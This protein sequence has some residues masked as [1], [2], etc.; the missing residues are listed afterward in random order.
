MHTQW[1]RVQAIL[2]HVVAPVL[3]GGTIYVLWRSPRLLVFS[4]LRS[5]GLDPLIEACRHATAP[6]LAFLHAWSLNSMPDGLW[7]YSFT[8]FVLLVWHR[9]PNSIDKVLW[10]SAPGLLALGGEGLQWLGFVPGTFDVADTCACVVGAT[11]AVAWRHDDDPVRN[12]AALCK[13][14][15]L[16]RSLRNSRSILLR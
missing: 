16:N 4:W 8:S 5:V 15:A 2:A 9:V 12:G 11:L 14:D 6:M 1:T 13:N 10:V 7:V 3:L